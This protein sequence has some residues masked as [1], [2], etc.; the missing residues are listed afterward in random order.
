M[1][2]LRSVLLAFILLAISSVPTYADPSFSQV[3]VFGDSMTDTGA[4]DEGS[5][6]NLSNGYFNG[7]P[8][9]GGRNC[10]GPV[11]VEYAAE[12]LEIPLVNYSVSGA[13]TGE[14]NIIAIVYPQLLAYFPQIENT[15]VLSQLK[16]FEDSLNEKFD[17]PKALF[18]Y[19]AGSN[20]LLNATEDDLL[21][22]INTAL[23]NIETALVTLTNLGARNIL[24]AT[25]PI[26]PEFSSQNN[27]NGVIFN[28]R[29]R[30]LVQQ[31]N[32][33]LIS[34]IQI[35]EAFDLIS[36]MTY[37]STA[38][39]FVET[40]ARCSTDVNCYS[41]PEVSETYIT[42]DDAHQTTRVHELLAE[43]LVFQALNMING[44]GMGN[45]G[46]SPGL[47]K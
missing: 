8:N 47:I 2:V 1:I 32:E 11:V 7:P 18:I 5:L 25:R 15:G 38:Y 29:L 9:V 44:R 39:G 31:L 28:A 45:H 40:T 20:D 16:E 21:E 19:W 43:N 46:N 26:R 13:T 22:R 37:N 41:N 33:N 6:Y 3:I 24:V 17:D 10:N 35:F 14:K 34:N 27:I 23:D 4:A 30:V 42:W 36:D 12:T